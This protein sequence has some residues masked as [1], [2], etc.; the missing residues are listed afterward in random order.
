MT[1]T[2]LNS[3][4][5]QPPQPLNQPTVRRLANGL[6]II[7]EHMPVDAVTLNIWL[8][9]GSA[10]EA[11]QING[12]AHFLEHMVFKGTPHLQAGEFERQVEQRGAVTNAATSQDYTHYYIT[13]APQDFAELAPLQVEVVMNASI[14][15]DSFERER[16][17]VLE[18]IRRSQDN[19]QRR[20]FRHGS[21]VSFDRLPYRRPVLGPAE[22]IETLTAQ[23]MRDFHARWYQPQSM[24][25]VVVGNLPVEQLLDIVER[26]FAQAGDHKRE[27]SQIQ[28]DARNPLSDNSC[29]NLGSPI[30][31]ET[32]LPSFLLDSATLDLIPE[33]PFSE[34]VRRD[35]VDDTLQQARLMMIW[36]VPG[37]NNLS[38]TYALDVLA[39][40]LGRGRTSRLVRDLREERGLVSSI[41][42]S[43]VTYQQQGAFYISAQLPDVHLA[44]VEQAIME[45]VR[46]IQ[47]ELISEFEIAKVRTRTANQFVFGNE[48]PSDRSGL[49]G[50]YHALVGDLEPAICY[51]QCI[52]AIDAEAVCLAAQH[53]LSAQ[54]YGIVTIRTQPIQ[55]AGVEPA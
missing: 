3:T 47:T 26:S 16:Q 41:S 15:D 34:I 13:T 46:T 51:P 44:T 39:S 43:N 37:L 2:L 8:N 54:S 27:R 12:M 10:I 4:Q 1:A 23:Q 38:E 21:E 35:L 28:S 17:V 6:T 33:S 50:Y 25:A 52:Q 20:S 18:E 30:T 36:R 14:S 24:T 11:D 32:E 19:A 53:Y 48:T 9:V 7:A 29:L 49:Y 55:G 45:H 40:I 31:N 22:V 42:A 5:S